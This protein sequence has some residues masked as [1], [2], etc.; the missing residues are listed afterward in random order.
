MGRGIGR[1]QAVTAVRPSR[2]TGVQRVRRAV[3][4]EPRRTPRTPR[5]VGRDRGGVPRTGTAARWAG[6]AQEGD[7]EP[8]SSMRGSRG[9]G[10]VG[11]P[12]PRVLETEIGVEVQWIDLGLRTY[13]QTHHVRTEQ[14]AGLRAGDQSGS[15]LCTR[16]HANDVVLVHHELL[17]ALRRLPRHALTDIVRDLPSDE[18]LRE[19]ER[20]SDAPRACLCWKAGVRRSGLDLAQI[21][22]SRFAPVLGSR[23]RAV[24][25]L[26]S[27]CPPLQL[28]QPV[29][30][31]YCLITSCA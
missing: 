16:A 20:N 23:A 4:Q 2:A 10:T 12:L 14:P 21:P 5:L 22:E 31:P 30:V 24:A 7:P 3:D 8:Q 1:R 26:R 13:T 29:S 6:I 17:E 19:D 9:C 28:A 11:H 15:L 18:I 27:R 25:V